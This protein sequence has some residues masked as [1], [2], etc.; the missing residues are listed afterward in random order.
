[1]PC[2]GGAGPP[3]TSEMGEEVVEMTAF[4]GGLGDDRPCC[5]GEKSIDPAHGLPVVVLAGEPA[6]RRWVKLAY[7][8]G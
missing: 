2:K 8:S 4:Q 3:E 7:L 1:M 5:G 6:G